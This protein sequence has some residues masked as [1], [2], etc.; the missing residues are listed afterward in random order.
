VTDEEGFVF[1]AEDLEEGEPEFEETE[2]IKIHKLP[3]EEAVQWVMEGKITDGISIAGI[4]KV[5]KLLPK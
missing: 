4:L 2:V 3:F 1:L 5:S